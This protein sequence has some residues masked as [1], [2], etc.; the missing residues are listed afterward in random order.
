MNLIQTIHSVRVEA[1]NI[2]VRLTACLSSNYFPVVSPVETD[3]LAA[4][5]SF[6][7]INF[8]HGPL[9]TYRR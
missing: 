5:Y 3:R 4:R 8:L 9:S 1:S 7:L 2:D 6:A